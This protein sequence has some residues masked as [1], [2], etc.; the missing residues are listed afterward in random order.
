MFLAIGM[1]S[2]VETYLTLLGLP[3]EPVPEF[4]PSTEI[5]HLQ[6]QANFSPYEEKERIKAEIKAQA[7]YREG[8]PT[9]P[10]L[11]QIISAIPA[12]NREE[13]KIIAR[14]ALH[15]L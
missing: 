5:Q 6:E 9:H 15:G 3:P 13:R 10:S 4:I 12:F 14:H 1:I 8:Q 7:Q 11:E 2:K